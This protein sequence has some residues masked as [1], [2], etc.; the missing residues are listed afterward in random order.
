M[1]TDEQ[2]YAYWLEQQ[3]DVS[4]EELDAALVALYG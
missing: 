3:D 2:E 1:P 4:D